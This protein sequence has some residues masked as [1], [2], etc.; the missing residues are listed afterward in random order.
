MMKWKTKPVSV[1]AIRWNGTN[2]EEMEAFGINAGLD[3]LAVGS[4]IV[5]NG[6]NR[7]HVYSEKAFYEMHE[8]DLIWDENI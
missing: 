5:K 4:Y 2:V 3:T 7:F 6:R 1:E 8:R